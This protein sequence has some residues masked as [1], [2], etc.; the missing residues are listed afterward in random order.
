MEQKTWPT[1]R[2]TDGQTLP[3]GTSREHISD[4]TGWI[5]V[6]GPPVFIPGTQTTFIFEGQPP[7]TGPFP[8]K[9]MVIWVI[10]FLP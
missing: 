1:L 8:T 6:K 9:T 4:V 2:G 10:P 3:F 5:V 7:K